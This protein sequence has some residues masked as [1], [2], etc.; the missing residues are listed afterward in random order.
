MSCAAAV[1]AAISSAVQSR[2]A[3][4]HGTKQADIRFPNLPHIKPRDS[5]AAI[6]AVLTSGRLWAYD[7]GWIWQLIVR[8]VHK[9]RM[10]CRGGTQSAPCCMANMADAHM[11][12]KRVF[13][14]LGWSRC[15]RSR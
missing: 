13:T 4:K 3:A 6:V 1:E 5:S 14:D 11:A 15:Y 2:L 10:P 7:C 9:L 12:G 8:C